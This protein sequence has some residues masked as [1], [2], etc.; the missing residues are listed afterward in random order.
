[1]GRNLAESKL[2]I[3]LMGTIASGKGT[4]AS[5]LVDRWGFKRIILGNL[6]RALA[7]KQ[8]IKPTRENLHNLQAKYRAKDQ[9]YFIKKVIAK[10]GKSKYDKWV[11]DG[12]RNPEDA[13]WLKK[14]FD[15]KLVF[16]DAPLKLRWERAKKRRRGKEKEESLGEFKKIEKEENR[17]F[18]FN[19][20]KRYADFKIIN[21]G[22]KE[23]AWR[24]MER[25]LSEIGLK[26]K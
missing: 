20:T 1:M 25:I 26:T 2:V 10:I 17:I 21:D 6:V 8:G 19:I 4:V 5:Y 11:V 9:A 24:E 13:R 16:I 12:L 22:S 3:G 7:R 15:A 23:K 18:H 14:F